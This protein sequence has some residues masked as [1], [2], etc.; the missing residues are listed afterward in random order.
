[1]V[2]RLNNKG[3]AITT[4]VYG[5][6]IMSTMILTLIMSLLATT[7]VNNNNLSKTIEQELNRYSKTTVV[8]SSSEEGQE[9][10]VPEGEA[11]WYRIELWGAQGGGNNGGL[12]AYTSGIIKLDEGDIFSIRKFGKYRFEGIVGRTKKDNFIISID[13]Y[14]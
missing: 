14:I 13:K 9:Y 1:M 11:G 7:R 10:I 4:I 5:L 6:A 3:F 8:F 2:K 12:G